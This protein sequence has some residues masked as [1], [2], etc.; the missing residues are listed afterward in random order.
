MK[1]TR[2]GE[3]TWQKL[4]PSRALL[5]LLSIGFIDL[6]A[7]A[8]LHANGLIVELNPLMKPIIETSEWLFAA[9]KG[10][11]LLLAWAVM[12]KNFETHKEFVRRASVAGAAAYV[13]IWTIW[14]IAGSI[15]MA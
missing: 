7:T 14:F 2:L 6:V 1:E 8:V 3:T 5:L 10:M 9:V 12:V 13:V 11:T 15:H 4:F